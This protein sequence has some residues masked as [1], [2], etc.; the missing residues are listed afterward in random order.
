M[1]FAESDVAKATA[2]EEPPVGTHT[3]MDWH[4]VSP[5]RLRDAA[6]FSRLL[7]QAAK[8][9][10]A[11]PLSTPVLHCF[12]GGG[13]TGFLPLAESHIAVHTYPERGYLAADVFTCGG[14]TLEAAVAVFRET[15]RPQH[16]ETRTLT[17]GAPVN[18]SGR[19]AIEPPS[20]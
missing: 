7:L 12:P 5:S 9:A 3:L 2:P 20:R 15:L 11:T 19:E 10:G 4:G 14:C 18:R 6:L 8:A 17:R 1:T 13:L 16:E